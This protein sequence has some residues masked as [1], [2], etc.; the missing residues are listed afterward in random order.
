[1]ISLDNTEEKLGR[2]PVFIVSQSLV[3][4]EVVISPAFGPS[5]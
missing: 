5:V 4:L 3:M 1:M 2:S